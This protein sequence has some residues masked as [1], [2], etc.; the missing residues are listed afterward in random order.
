[1][2]EC[3]EIKICP[4]CLEELII[5]NRENKI[6]TNEC[7]QGQFHEKCLKDWSKN[8]PLCRYNHEVFQDIVLDP[9]DTD[10]FLDQSQSNINGLVGVIFYLASVFTIILVLLFAYYSTR[11]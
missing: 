2:I 8:C 9:S 11:K 1:M 5:D 6:V 4:I 7:C 3:Q 10:Q